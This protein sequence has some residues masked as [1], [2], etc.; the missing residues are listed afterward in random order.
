MV[1]LETEDAAVAAPESPNREAQDDQEGIC[2][3]ESW[4]PHGGGTRKLCRGRRNLGSWKGL[5]WGGGVVLG[6]F[7]ELLSGE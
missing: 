2:C 3:R 1:H 7:G 4:T 5:R 6:E